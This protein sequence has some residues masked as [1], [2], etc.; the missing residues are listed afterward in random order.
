MSVWDWNASCPAAPHQSPHYTLKELII[1][2]RNRG[3]S[4]WRSR[5]PI[6]HR[7]YAWGPFRHLAVRHKSCRTARCYCTGCAAALVTLLIF[8]YYIILSLISHLCCM[9]ETCKNGKVKDFMLTSEWILIPEVCFHGRPAPIIIYS[10]FWIYV[11]MTA[12]ITT[13]LLQSDKASV[14]YQLQPFNGKVPNAAATGWPLR[15]S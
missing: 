9:V 7:K 10:M 6:E 15:L 13:T 2:V 3:F 5:T 14:A 8:Y 4:I 1:S 11:L 12:R